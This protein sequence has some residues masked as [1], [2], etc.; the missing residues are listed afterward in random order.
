MHHVFL[1]IFLPSLHD[2]N[3]KLPNFTFVEDCNKRQHISFSFPELWCSPLEFNSQKLCQHLT[4]LRRWNT[5]D[6]V[7]SNANSLCKWRF[8]SR[9]RRLR[10]CINSLIFPKRW[11]LW[12]VSEMIDV[13]KSFAL[14]TME[15]WFWWQRNEGNKI[16][17][18]KF[19]LPNFVAWLDL[20]Y[21][22]FVKFVHHANI[23]D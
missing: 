23:S 8:C 1:Y 6:R 15:E 3:V 12:V 11:A 10:R 18:W 9:S 5:C 22:L 4:N 21:C 20:A 7:W 17:E 13:C 2:C 19:Y 16:S 14:R